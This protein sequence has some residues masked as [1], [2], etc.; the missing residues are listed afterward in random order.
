[1]KYVAHKGFRDTMQ[2]DVPMR[3]SLKLYKSIF[4]LAVIYSCP[5]QYFA[6]DVLL[7]YSEKR[8]VEN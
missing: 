8:D 7:P 1:M 4:K 5:G 6:I 2:Y 3:D